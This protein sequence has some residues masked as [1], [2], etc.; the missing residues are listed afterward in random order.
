MN[1]KIVKE[2]TTKNLLNT[3]QTSSMGN[4]LIEVIFTEDDQRDPVSIYY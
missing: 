4:L 3:Y 1:G 2:D